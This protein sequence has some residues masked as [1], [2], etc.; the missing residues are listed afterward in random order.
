[1]SKGFFSFAE[2]LEAPGLYGVV[3]MRCAMC[4]LC[5]AVFLGRIIALLAIF[6]TSNL[7]TSYAKE[8]DIPRLADAIYKAEGGSKTSHP[9][10]ILKHY[11]T[12]TPRQACINTIKS[13]LKRYKASKSQEDFILFMS[14]SYCPIGASND[15]YGLNKHWVKNVRFFYGKS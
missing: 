2:Q 13:N 9:Y 11:K 15:P 10:G 14:R 12:T 5:K 4:D 3:E 1:M 8:I 7:A 6:L